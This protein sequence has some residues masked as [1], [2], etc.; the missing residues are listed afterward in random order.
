M[1]YC[2]WQSNDFLISPRRAKGTRFWS[3]VDSGNVDS[4]NVDSNADCNVDCKVNVA[5]PSVNPTKS[6]G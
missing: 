4:G 5:I 6:L 1:I 3:N 2:H